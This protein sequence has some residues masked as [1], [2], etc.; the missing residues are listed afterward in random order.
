[1]LPAILFLLYYHVRVSCKTFPTMLYLRKAA[2]HNQ[3][4]GQCRLTVQLVM[5]NI[6]TVELIRASQSTKWYKSRIRPNNPFAEN[7]M[8]SNILLATFARPQFPSW[9]GA[10]KV[11]EKDKRE[12]NPALSEG[13]WVRGGHGSMGRR[14]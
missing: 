3:F 10:D 13:R 4:Q 8:A 5:Y 11:V 6:T 1:M 9:V 2:S 7:T 14:R 12:V